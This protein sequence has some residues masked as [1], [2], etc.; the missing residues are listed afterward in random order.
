[1]VYDAKIIVS[2]FA[3]LFTEHEIAPITQVPYLVAYN[4]WQ[5]TVIFR[6]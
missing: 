6:K 1:M 4:E 5:S 2:T 3:G